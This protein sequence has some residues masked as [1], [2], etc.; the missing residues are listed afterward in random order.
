M[1]EAEEVISKSTDR[2]LTVLALLVL[3]GLASAVV[4][5]TVKIW[6]LLPLGP[7]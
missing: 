4:Y 7:G 3:L 2:V 1:E 5:Y 6:R